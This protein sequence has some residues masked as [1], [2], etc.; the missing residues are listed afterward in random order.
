MGVSSPIARLF[1]SRYG[2]MFAFAAKIG[3]A[4]KRETATTVTALFVSYTSSNVRL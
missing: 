3:A 2:E 4:T 1:V